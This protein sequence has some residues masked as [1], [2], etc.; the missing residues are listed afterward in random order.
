MAP[1]F[2]PILGCDCVEGKCG[3]AAVDCGE[4]RMCSV[5]LIAAALNTR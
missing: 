2:C 3:W 1:K 4:F 5:Q